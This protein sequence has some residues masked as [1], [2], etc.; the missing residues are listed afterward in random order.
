M[1]RNLGYEVLAS[2]TSLNMPGKL[3]IAAS[4][5]KLIFRWQSEKILNNPGKTGTSGNTPIE[6][7]EA[8][9]K[10]KNVICACAIRFSQDLFNVENKVEM[11]SPRLLQNSMPM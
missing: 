8:D 9:D 6:E 2:K 4:S 3:R 11:M 5:M 1:V 10:V 7:S